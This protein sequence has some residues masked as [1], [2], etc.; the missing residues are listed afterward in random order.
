ML[1]MRVIAGKAK[2]RILKSP[3]GLRTRPMTELARGALFS[4]LEAVAQ[5]WSRV[6]DLYSGTGSLGIEALSRDA[7][8][9]DFVEQNNA[10][11]K[12][13]KENLETTGFA[14][15]GRVYCK[16]VT[17]A[18]SFL[19]GKYGLVLVDPPYAE[20]NLDRL[21]ERIATSELVREGTTVAIHHWHRRPLAPAYGNFQLKDSRSYG[22]SSISIYQQ[23]EQT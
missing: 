3:R 5:D 9:V 15:Q 6:L 17:G 18:L 2:G 13:I 12:I 8:E 4:I 23:E 16:S 19:S 10:C 22:D 11:C 7:G 20:P 21:L 14:Q 1:R